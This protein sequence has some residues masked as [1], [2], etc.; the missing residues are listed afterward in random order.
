ML[1]VQALTKQIIKPDHLSDR[2]TG[3]CCRRSNEEINLKRHQPIPPL[4]LDI[5]TAKDDYR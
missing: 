1:N 5:N 3:A 4:H 2:H